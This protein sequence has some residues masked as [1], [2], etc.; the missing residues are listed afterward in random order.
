MHRICTQYKIQGSQ[1][2]L[3]RTPAGSPFSNLFSVDKTQYA[4][5]QCFSKFVES[6]MQKIPSFI[7]LPLVNYCSRYLGVDY[8]YSFL[9]ENH[10]QKFI[11]IRRW[12]SHF[13]T[14]AAFP[15]S[16]LFVSFQVESF[17]ETLNSVSNRDRGTYMKLVCRERN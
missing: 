4:E 17:C 3:W 13:C 1:S 10:F 5:F 14:T 16:S 15:L 11:P 7:P 8:V 12:N 2:K 6:N 9:F